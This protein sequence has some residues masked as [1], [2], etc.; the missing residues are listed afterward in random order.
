MYAYIRIYKSKSASAS[1]SLVSMT[2]DQFLISSPVSFVSISSYFNFISLS[3][4][5]TNNGILPPCKV[6]TWFHFP[7]CSTPSDLTTFCRNGDS[8]LLFFILYRLVGFSHLSRFLFAISWLVL[9]SPPCTSFS[10]SVSPRGLFSNFCLL[11]ICCSRLRYKLYFN[12]SQS[13]CSVYKQY[14]IYQD[15][16]SLFYFLNWSIRNYFILVHFSFT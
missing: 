13:C 6:A 4:G 3:T 12:F 10:W 5:T 7:C 9:C 16:Q 1:S 8:A 15:S 14:F 11:R 2:L